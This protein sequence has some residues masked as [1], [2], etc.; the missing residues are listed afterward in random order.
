MYIEISGRCTGKSARLVQHLISHVLSGNKNHACV[1]VPNMAMGKH[2]RDNIRQAIDHSYKNT[3]IHP[4]VDKRIH[5]STSYRENINHLVA[6]NVSPKNVWYYW[7]EADHCKPGQLLPKSQGFYVTTLRFE[8]NTEEWSNWENDQF[9]RIIV[10]NGC[11]YNTYHGI[12]SFITESRMEDFKNY[13]KS[14][15]AEQFKAEYMCDPNPRHTYDNRS[16]RVVKQ[17]QWKHPAKFNDGQFIDLRE[18][19]DCDLTKLAEFFEDDNV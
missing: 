2:L 6:H 19:S 11:H 16:D 12:K 10:A 18:I 3:R 7:D 9:L 13:S 8:R 14:M 5:I 17:Y 1:V 4:K 15:S